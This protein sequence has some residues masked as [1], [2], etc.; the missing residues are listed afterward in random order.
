MFV[1]RRQGAGFGFRVGLGITILSCQI[2]ILGALAL[3][4]GNMSRILSDDDIAA[5]VPAELAGER[6]PV[7]TAIVS[8]DEFYPT[9]QTDA[10]REVESIIRA[11]RYPW[12]RKY[13]ATVTPR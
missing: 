13:S 12:S 3:H 4:E 7:P 6:T 10:Q 1:R 9:P 8:S 5:L 2:A 11:T